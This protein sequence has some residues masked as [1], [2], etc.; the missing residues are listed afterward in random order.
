MPG[1]LGFYFCMRKIGADRSLPH[2]ASSSWSCVLE[3]Q[4]RSPSCVLTFTLGFP[5]L[6]VWFCILLSSL[7]PLHYSP[8]GGSGTMNMNKKSSSPEQSPNLRG[9]RAIH[10]ILFFFLIML[11]CWAGETQ[12]I[13]CL[14]CHSILRQEP[15][16]VQHLISI[17]ERIWAFKGMG[18]GTNEVV[19]DAF[20][21]PAW[22]SLEPTFNATLMFE[23][24]SWG[25]YWIKSRERPQS[26]RDEF[27]EILI[28][29]LAYRWG[30]WT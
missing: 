5:L 8:M 20:E 29:F 24:R 26:T 30:V 19:K 16:A 25:T 18:I 12:T 10:C 21:A 13:Y 1:H 17:M 6:L 7:F 23:I 14:T 4:T 15:S 2:P 11:H 28:L 27:F 3:V 22:N 9:E